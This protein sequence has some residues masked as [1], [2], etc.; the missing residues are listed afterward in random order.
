MRKKTGRTNCRKFRFKDLFVSRRQADDDGGWIIFDDSSSPARLP[1]RGRVRRRSYVVKGFAVI[2]LSVSLPLCAKWGYERFFFENEEFV[3]RRLNIQTDG[4][5]S[6]ARLAEIANVAAGMN[7]M[8]L[9][10]SAIQGQI[11]K[12][13]QVEKV[14]VTREL[15]DRLNL[16]VRERMPVAWLS[17]PV[18]GIRPWDM[19]RGYLL[20]ADGFLFRCLDLNDG[21]KSL[22]VVESFR[23]S[24]PVEGTKIESEGVRAGL[25]L[26]QESDK[27]F[28]GQGLNVVEVR[29]RD[30][31]AVECLYEGELLV[32]FGV[33]DFNR[34]L[35]DLAMILEQAA[36]S[37]QHLATVNVAAVKNIPVTF[38]GP[39]GTAQTDVAN[40]LSEGSPDSAAAGTSD[41]R[42]KEQEKHLRSILNG[43]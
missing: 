18:L 5:L 15:P 24:D 7:L 29:V 4:I 34:G 27:R 20:D 38:A 16:I 32:T 43:G 13:P 25:R 35:D 1:E 23:I 42:D 9:D 28:L 41:T 12:V 22:P 30:E 26:I 37:G 36:G 11:E 8:E 14:S 10:L 31:W 17:S 19:E 6:E 3:L 40:G 33:F 39:V 21:M 2:C